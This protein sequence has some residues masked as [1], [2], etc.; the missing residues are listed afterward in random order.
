ME[1]SLVALQLVMCC[2]CG[3][4]L[5]ADSVSQIR[6][7]VAVEATRLIGSV[8]I[9]GGSWAATLFVSGML[10]EEENQLHCAAALSAPLSILPVLTL[11]S[12]F[13]VF[14]TSR[15]AWCIFI[16]LNQF[17]IGVVARS[18]NR[19]FCWRSL[20]RFGANSPRASALRVALALS[21]A[22]KVDEP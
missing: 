7:D 18:V 22:C 17:G 1:L 8:L 5:V 14:S 2:V 15:A 20:K 12:P 11:T 13:G 19:D 16:L 10:A 21:A 4:L 9:L 3:A 6:T